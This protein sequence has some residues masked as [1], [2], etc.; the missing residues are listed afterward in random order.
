[1]ELVGQLATAIF[2]GALLGIAYRLSDG[3]KYASLVVFVLALIFSV[4]LLFYINVS[5]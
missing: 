3:K 2:L 4:I 5:K 1:M